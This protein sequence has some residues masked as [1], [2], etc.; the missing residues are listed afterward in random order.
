MPNRWAGRYAASDWSSIT[1]GR[2]CRKK[3]IRTKEQPAK[4]HPLRCNA[5]L[6]SA[7]RRYF[8]LCSPWSTE[9]T[10]QQRSKPLQPLLNVES[11]RN[12]ALVLDRQKGENGGWGPGAS[13]IDAHIIR[14]VPHTYRGGKNILTCKIFGLCWK[15]IVS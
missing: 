4:C 5:R 6:P 11:S 7:K 3:R 2:R 9:Q 8:M 13:R 10:R 15:G 12:L 1:I 14:Y